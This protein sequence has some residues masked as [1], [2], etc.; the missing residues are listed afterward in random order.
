M[1]AVYEA[2]QSAGAAI[3]PL[4]SIDEIAAFFLAT[5]SVSR[6]VLNRAQHVAARCSERLLAAV[7]M[8]NNLLE[9]VGA[10][11]HVEKLLAVLPPSDGTMLMTDRSTCVVCGDGELLPMLRFERSLEHY[12]YQLP[13]YT[14]TGV[15]KVELCVK[16]CA[17][18][19]AKHGLSY[20]WGGTLLGS[21]E[22]MPF[23]GA[24]DARYFHATTSAMWETSLLR[25]YE[26]QA[27]NSHSGFLTFMN[28]YRF[29]H[30]FLPC[31]M[32]RAPRVLTHVFL[33]WT[34]LRWRAEYSLPVHRC[35]L[36]DAEARDEEMSDLHATLLAGR[37]ELHAGYRAAWARAHETCC[38]NPGKCIAQAV[39]GH[40]K[41]R[42]PLCENRWARMCN[43]GPL[44]VIT[45]N[46]SHSPLAGGKFCKV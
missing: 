2:F 36:G 18:C 25:D 31:S 45:F 19:K 13:L 26:A 1:A 27:L 41:G 46:C 40:M 9:S 29:K 42:R 11:P 22:Q 21:G 24:T 20:A 7:P 14:P 28:E 8:V 16:Q 23:E 32:K 17:V 30:R 35:K 3:A 15:R 12:S 10:M 5:A 6:G 34:Y 39:D 43:L 37:E 4:R 33:A 38:R 44:G